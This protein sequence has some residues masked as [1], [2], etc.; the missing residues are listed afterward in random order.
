[1][2]HRTSTDDGFRARVRTTLY[3]FESRMDGIACAFTC[4]PGS[5]RTGVLGH[6]QSSLRDWSVLSG[7]PRTYVLGYSQ[8]SL[9]DCSVTRVMHR[10]NRESEGKSSGI[11]H[12]AKNERDG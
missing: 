2:P 4:V 6:S 10:M 8:P 5:P 7:S 9:R 1:M 3:Q 12:L 11:P